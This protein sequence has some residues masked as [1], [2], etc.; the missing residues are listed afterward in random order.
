PGASPG[1]P[2]LAPGVSPHPRPFPT[3]VDGHHFPR[4]HPFV[5]VEHAPHGPHRGQRIA[6]E[7]QRDV[8]HLVEPYAVLT[9]DR[10]AGGDTRRHDLAARLLHT[11][12][13]AGYAPV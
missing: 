10:S 12:L 8:A 7:D 9:R 13:E 3:R 1:I 5:G 2:G 11:R 4:V 6:V